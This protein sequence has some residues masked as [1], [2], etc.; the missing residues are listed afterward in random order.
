MIRRSVELPV[1]F[2]ESTAEFTRTLARVEERT[3]N[4]SAA[5]PDENFFELVGAIH[6][7]S[8]A[9]L[10]M[11]DYL[12]DPAEIKDAQSQFQEIIAPWFDQSWFMQRGKAKPRGYPGD[13]ELLTGIY[14]GEPKSRGF[15]GYL[16]LYFL[17]SDLGRAVPARMAATRDYLNRQI[18]MR[19]GDI[20]ILNV[21][22]GPCQEY[23]SG[24]EMDNAKR[25]SVWCVD[26]DQAALDFVQAK[27]ESFTQPLPQL[28]FHKYNVLRMMS[29]QRNLDLFGQ[30][31]IVYS[32]G[33]LDYI[34]DQHLVPIL[35]GLGVMLKPNG[36]LFVAFKDAL[37]YDRAE[38]QWF[39][40]WFFFPRYERECSELWRRAGYAMENVHQTWDATRIILNYEF[41]ATVPRTRTD[42]PEAR[43]RYRRTVPISI[44]GELGTP[45]AIPE[46]P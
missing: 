41:T 28:R 26:N 11:E 42:P 7:M 44:G 24:L 13:F 45:A 10:R 3:R 1:R 21:A 35:D 40:D 38:Y 19:S 46:S 6:K 12:R 2:Q 39:V 33:L 37:G 18:A 30:F 27:A 29:R 23:F 22:S 16:D 25:V 9:C 32:I 4:L 15:G 36:S 34:P 20:R 31:D 5:K 43:K 17:R 14:G 8:A